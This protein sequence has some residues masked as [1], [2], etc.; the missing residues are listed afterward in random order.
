MHQE[1]LSLEEERE[2]AG[3]ES[4]QLHHVGQTSIIHEGIFVVRLHLCL[5]DGEG[6][7][8]QQVGSKPLQDAPWSSIA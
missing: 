8:N 6:I 7:K 1:V 2:V 5:E 3:V 4:H